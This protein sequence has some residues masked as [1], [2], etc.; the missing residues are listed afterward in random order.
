MPETAPGH[1]RRKYT[2]GVYRRESN[3]LSLI[4]LLTAGLMAVDVSLT[5]DI[6]VLHPGSVAYLYV[7]VDDREH[8]R[9]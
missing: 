3:E 1:P 4:G 7:I 9:H 5:H 2:I 6:H 8:Q